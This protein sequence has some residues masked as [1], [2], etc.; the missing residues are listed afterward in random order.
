MYLAMAS[1]EE[2]RRYLE[3]SMRRFNVILTEAGAEGADEEDVVA[4]EGEADL[5]NG[6]REEDVEASEGEADPGRHDQGD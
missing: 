6:N 4:S 5:G 2:D 3:R 1:D